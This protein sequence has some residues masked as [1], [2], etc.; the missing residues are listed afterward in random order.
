MSTIVHFPFTAYQNYLKKEIPHWLNWHKD[1]LHFKGKKLILFYE[2]MLLDLHKSLKMLC[3][4]LNVKKV[5]TEE[6]IQ[7]VIENSKG[8]FKRKKHVQEGNYYT[9]ANKKQIEDYKK[10]VYKL[11]GDCIDRG[12]CIADHKLTV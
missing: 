5:C 10:T 3:E 4:Y 11:L 9:N 2:D 8:N 6:R 1:W 12:E 7:C